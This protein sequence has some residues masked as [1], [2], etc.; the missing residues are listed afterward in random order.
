M[1]D[2][3]QSQG[4]ALWAPD[5]P[6][7]GRPYLVPETAETQNVQAAAEGVVL[8]DGDYVEFYGEK[9]RLADRVGTMPMLAF[10]NA[11]KKGLDSDDMEGLAAM[12]AMIRGVIHRPPLLD[13]KGERVRDENGKLLRDESEWR[14]FESLA[15]D[16]CAEGDEIMDFVSRAM[17]VMSAR[18]RKPREISSGGS[19]PTSEK[20]KDASSSPVT[21]PGAEGLTPVSA[22]GR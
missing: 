19:R 12:Y 2:Y 7:A 22:L 11:S 5:Q 10:A 6:L 9:F 16:E 17:E 3:P 1:A 18:P 15:E 14:R 21:R 8:D 13:D 20:S 4:A